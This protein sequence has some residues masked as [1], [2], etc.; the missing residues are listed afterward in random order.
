MTNYNRNVIAAKLLAPTIER[1]MERIL[2]RWHAVEDEQKR[3]CER[4]GY[5]MK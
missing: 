2:E 1:R 4:E 3:Q 5:E